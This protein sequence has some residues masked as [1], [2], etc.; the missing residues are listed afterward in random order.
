MAEMHSQARASSPYELVPNILR[1]TVNN[2]SILHRRV[3]VIST[4]VDSNR[5]RCKQ[6]TP[7][8]AAPKRL[9]R[10]NMIP[11]ASQPVFVVSDQ[12]NDNR[13]EQPQKMA[14]GLKF[15]I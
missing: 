9:V 11:D 5:K 2:L 8:N 10:N 12:V 4:R 1:Y 14:R 3:C 15:W 6:L 13:A 7:R